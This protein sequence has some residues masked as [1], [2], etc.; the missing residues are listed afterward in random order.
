MAAI[1]SHSAFSSG[2]G[3]RELS[4]VFPA[5]RLDFATGFGF[6][7]ADFVATG[8]GFLSVVLTTGFFSRFFAPV[9]VVLVFVAVGSFFFSV[10]VFEPVGLEA[11]VLVD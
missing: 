10:V 6:L 2:F 5:G 11:T 1:L 9:L 4:E 3:P 8:V 7:S